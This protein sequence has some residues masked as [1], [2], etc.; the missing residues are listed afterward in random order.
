MKFHLLR[1]YP[2]G[3]I[4][5]YG[6]FSCDEKGMEALRAMEKKVSKYATDGVSYLMEAP[7]DPTKM[8]SRIY[9]Y[10]RTK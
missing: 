5:T 3:S 7:D 10:E 8:E 4:G 1:M 6:P 2:G 9:K